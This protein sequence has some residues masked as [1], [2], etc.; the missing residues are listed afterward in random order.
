MTGSTV[1][2]VGTV[3]I[4]V[5]QEFPRVYFISGLVLGSLELMILKAVA[6]SG[7]LVDIPV[8]RK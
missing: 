1:V 2:F 4:E 7:L 5:F 3:A 8:I 6:I